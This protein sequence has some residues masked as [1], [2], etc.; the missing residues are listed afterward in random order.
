MWCGEHPYIRGQIISSDP[1]RRTSPV[2]HDR[3]RRSPGPYRLQ[4]SAPGF[5]TQIKTNVTLSAGEA[6]LG[7]F[8]LE[9][10]PAAYSF[11]VL[12]GSNA[13]TYRLVLLRG[14]EPE[15]GRVA[16]CPDDDHAAPL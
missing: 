9:V 14:G 4:A 10:Q 13:R 11:R 5:Q 12:N 7:E 6:A 1:I 16:R 8:H 3:Y 15:L 2:Y